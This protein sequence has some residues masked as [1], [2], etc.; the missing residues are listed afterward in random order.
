MSFS[1]ATHVIIIVPAAI[2]VVQLVLRAA[3]MVA[4]DADTIT[5]LQEITKQ[6]LLLESIGTIDQCEVHMYVI[7][8]LFLSSFI[9]KIIPRRISWRL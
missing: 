5:A 4:R 2:M 7:Y 1:H 6:C 9:A 3:T 8:I